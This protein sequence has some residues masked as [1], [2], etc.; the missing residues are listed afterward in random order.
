M[1]NKKLDAEDVLRYVLGGFFV[2]MLLASAVH[3]VSNSSI[4][5]FLFKATSANSE[6]KRDTCILCSVVD[7]GDVAAIK[8]M[9]DSGVDPNGVSELQGF[10]ALMG[11][12][13]KGRGDIVK[14][15]LAAGANPNA[16]AG[17]GETAL[18]FA[19]T[20]GHVDIVNMLVSAGAD[21]GAKDK[22]G[23]TALDHAKR[24][25]RS[26]V[27]TPEEEEKYAEIFRI[28]EEAE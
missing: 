6:A 10:T 9:L 18:I 11:A 1:G 27:Q 7:R 28:L 26:S 21:A 5:T 2:S 23:F 17:K 13:F 4:Y 14:L 3:A 22:I 8:E 15:L 16:A 25:S 20:H 12:S 24:Q 19:A